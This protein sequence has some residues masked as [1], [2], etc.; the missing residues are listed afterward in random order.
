MGSED[1]SSHFQASHEAVRNMCGLQE[2][3]CTI[4]TNEM[5][6]DGLA[7]ADRKMRVKSGLL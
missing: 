3:D 1:V 5:E 6:E 7:A 4:V 2:K